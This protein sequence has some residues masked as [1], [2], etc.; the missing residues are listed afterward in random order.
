MVRSIAGD[1][2]LRSARRAAGTQ[3]VREAVRDLTLHALRSRMLTTEHIA[4]VART[5]G[6]G[7]ES[8]GVPPTA[9]VRETHRGAWAGLEDAVGQALHAIELAARQFAEGR[10]QLSQAEREQ[11]LAEIA[12]MERS[13]GD[14]WEYPRAV[15]ASLHA[16]IAS[17]TALLGQ[18]ATNRLASAA[19][20]GPP[21]A[22]G[23]LSFVASGV[24]LGLSEELREPPEGT[25]G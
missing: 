11:M 17:V 22:G 19:A 6:E 12:Q 4:A 24:L 9:P 18:A 15:P 16:R 8:S 20:D 2:L 3:N 7:I 25:A 21:G 10:A 13:L 1:E 23:I 5:V 14:G